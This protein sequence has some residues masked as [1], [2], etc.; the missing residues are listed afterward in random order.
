MKTRQSND[1]IDHIGAAH[2]ENDIELS[3]LTGRALVY[4]EN[5]RGE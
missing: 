5:Q 4:D 1:L 3:W 2:I